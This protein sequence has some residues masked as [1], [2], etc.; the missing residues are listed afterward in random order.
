MYRIG[1]D[2]GGTKVKIGIVD[3]EYNIVNKTS[4]DTEAL[5]NSE[6]VIKKM[7]DATKELVKDTN[8]DINNIRGIGIGSPGAIDRKNGIVLY[9]NN[10]NWYNVP[11][12]KYFIE[13]FNC[14]VLIDNDATCATIGEYKAG[15]KEQYKNMVL[16]TLGTGVGSGIYIDGKYYDGSMGSSEMGHMCIVADGED[17]TCGEKGCLEAYASGTALYRET[18]KMIKKHPDSILAKHCQGEINGKNV[19]DANLEGCPYSKEIID[20]YVHYLG[21][22]LTNIVNIF[23]PEII[24]LGGGL[25]CHEEELFPPLNEYVNKHAYGKEKVYVARI[26]RARL[27]NNAGII[28]SACLID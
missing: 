20:N 1:I 15:I 26:E 10:F 9:S 19:F 28:G 25:S 16:L 7:I 21:I 6:Y 24:L 27:G 2:L 3:N 8:I 11:I 4:I 5:R 14:P 23:R 17:C 12:T 18:I 22:G 13:E